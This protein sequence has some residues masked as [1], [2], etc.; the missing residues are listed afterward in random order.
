MSSIRERM[1]ISTIADDARELALKHGLGLEIA[2]YCTAYN[3]DERF[4]ETDPLVSGRIQ[5]IP[6]RIL[7]APFNELC[8]AAIDPLVRDIAR[9]RYL[10]AAA[11]A[12]RYGADKIVVHT[13]F[14]PVV[15]YP[16]WFVEQ[17]VPFWKEVLREIPEHMTLC[18]E[19][20]ME[21]SPDIQRSILS[22][23]DDPRFLACVDVGHAS[24]VGAACT[25]A[26]WIV[27]L[28]S[29]LGHLHVHSNDGIQD[30]HMPL[31]E[32]VVDMVSVFSEFDRCPAGAT[33]TIENMHAAES[34]DWLLRHGI[35]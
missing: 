9:R 35:I 17:S 34:V 8:P 23:V 27:E 22:G 26:D 6:R 28:G 21:A 11:L 25:A 4:A 2:E 15:Y 24:A 7:H 14:V 20:V 33:V 5:G 10:Q 1:Y 30:R 19:N 16:S 3:M 12:A 13:G 29:R 18:L 32:G 31:G